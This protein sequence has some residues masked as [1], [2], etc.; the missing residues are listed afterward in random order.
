MRYYF[1]FS[2]FH[3]NLALLGSKQDKYSRLHFEFANKAGACNFKLA[4]LKFGS[5]AFK[6][7]LQ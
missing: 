6:I 7:S 2:L 3:L 4:R 5:G 1:H